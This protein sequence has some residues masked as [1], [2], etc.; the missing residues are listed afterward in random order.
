MKEISRSFN[1]EIRGESDLSAARKFY[2][3]E[4]HRYEENKKTN[5]SK[6]KHLRMFREIF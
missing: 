5:W 4:I 2:Q 1:F 3:I 6:I